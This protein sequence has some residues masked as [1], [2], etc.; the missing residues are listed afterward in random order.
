MLGAELG[1]LAT[2]FIGRNALA[3]DGMH[4]KK[5]VTPCSTQTRSRPATGGLSRLHIGLGWTEGSG[6]AE[7][8]LFMG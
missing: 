7:T 8:G 4:A 1:A 3:Q 6:K 5:A 2:G